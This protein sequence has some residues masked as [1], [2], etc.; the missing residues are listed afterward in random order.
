MSVNYYSNLSDNDKNEA[1]ILAIQYGEYEKF[2]KLLATIE[3]VNATDNSEGYWTPLM[4]AV[5]EESLDMVKKLVEAGA[6][7]NIRAT[8]LYSDEFPL[9]LAAYGCRGASY[10]YKYIR[11]KKIYDYLFSL[12]LPELQKIAEKNL[13]SR[14]NIMFN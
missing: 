7:V 11:S 1:L 13:N 4:Y 3:N 10:Y 5:L 12:T 2:E 9:N 6:D 8:G 14:T